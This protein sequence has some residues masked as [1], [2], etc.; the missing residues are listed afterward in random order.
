MLPSLDQIID[1]ARWTFETHLLSAFPDGVE[2]SYAQTIVVLLEYAALRAR[3]EP[4]ALDEERAELESLLTSRG[5]DLPPA[6]EGPAGQAQTERHISILR[7]LLND[8]IRSLPGDERGDVHRY[9]RNQL[10][11]EAR[12]MPD[13]GIRRA[14]AES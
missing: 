11:R 3:L 1:S 10:D 14:L 13:N 4:V 6:P 2:R 8:L 9:V 7:V 5:V 12:W